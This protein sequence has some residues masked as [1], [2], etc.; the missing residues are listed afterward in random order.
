MIRRR[1]FLDV[2][3]Y[4]GHSVLAG[5]D[6][7]FGFD[8]VYSFEPVRRLAEQIDAI[9]DP[10]LSVVTACLSRGFGSVT[11]YH[12]GTLAGSLFADA[13]EYE[14]STP[15]EI[16]EQIDV[17]TFLKAFTDPN[18]QIWIKLNC[19]GSEIEIV[20]GLLDGGHAAALR[21][22]LIDFDALKIPSRRHL[23]A[24]VVQRLKTEGVPF[25]TPEECQYG[26]ITNYGGVR[27]WLLLAGAGLPGLARRARS[28]A[29]NAGMARRGDI[30]GYHKMRVL[31]AL[32]FLAFLARSR[33][34]DRTA[35][36]RG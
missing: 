30:N 1:I 13:P 35:P 10:R 9:A 18:D 24:R 22:V 11:L 25:M 31:K 14:G 7:L 33:R 8:R 29:Y 32:P 19:E 34:S 21:G 16:V 2:G 28:L 20:E 17:S 26:M 12:P 23:V 36:S 6:P 4:I 3:G 27:N 5:L 15:P